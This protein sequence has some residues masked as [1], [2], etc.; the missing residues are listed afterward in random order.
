MN[1]H[2]CNQEKN[3]ERIFDKLDNIDN[4]LSE[5]NIVLVRNTESLEYHIKRT[6]LLQNSL[7]PVRRLYDSLVWV[8]GVILFVSA[9][10][11]FFV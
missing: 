11:K 7:K 8:V 3:I 6:D 1:N 5:M 10:W 4:K 2:N 9:I